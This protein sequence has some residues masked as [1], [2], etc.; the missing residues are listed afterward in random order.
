MIDL[1]NSFLKYHFYSRTM[2]HAAI[3]NKCCGQVNMLDM[4]IRK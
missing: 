4:E 2:Q 1:D 3:Y